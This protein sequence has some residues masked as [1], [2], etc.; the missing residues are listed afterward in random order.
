MKI[1]K[2]RKKLGK[3]GLVLLEHGDGWMVTDHGVKTP[4][5]HQFETLQGVHNWFNAIK[6]NLDDTPLEDLHTNRLTNKEAEQFDKD[7][8]DFCNE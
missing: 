1:F 8:K 6:D 3:K 4:F 7:F 2:L 5:E